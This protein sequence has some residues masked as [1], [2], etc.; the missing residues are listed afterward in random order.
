MTSLSNYQKEL[1]YLCE[2]EFEYVQGMSEGW[3]DK[4]KI[5][6]LMDRVYKNIKPIGMYVVPDGEEPPYIPTSQ[7]YQHYFVNKWG[8]KIIQFTAQPTFEICG[9]PASYW[10]DYKYISQSSGLTREQCTQCLGYSEEKI[11]LI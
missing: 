4:T 1:N 3:G 2:Q 8:D 10:V 11:N 6:V 7:F 5:E 9:K